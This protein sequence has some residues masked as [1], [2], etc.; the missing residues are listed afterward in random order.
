[1]YAQNSE[2][3]EAGNIFANVTRDVTKGVQNVLNDVVKD[4]KYDM[5][6]GTDYFNYV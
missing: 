1:M 6:M 5:S 3:T 2:V 4:I